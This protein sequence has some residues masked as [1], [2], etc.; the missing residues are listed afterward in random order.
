MLRDYSIPT[1]KNTDSFYEEMHIY[2]IKPKTKATE[3]SHL[4]LM[5]QFLTIFD[6]YDYRHLYYSFELTVQPRM[7]LS[8]QSSKNNET[9]LYLQMRKHVLETGEE[10]QR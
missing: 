4:G 5:K 8:S 2:K 6:I 10:A 3:T 7:T 1:L 9:K